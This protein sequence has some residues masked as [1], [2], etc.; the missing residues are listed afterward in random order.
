[1]P[2][3][4]DTLAGIEPGS[5]LDAIRNQRLQAR[6]HAQVSYESL[7]KPKSEA[8]ASRLERIAI[9]CFVAGLHGRPEIEAFYGTALAEAGAPAAWKTAIAAAVIAAKGQGP[10]G[11]YPKG[12][13]SAEDKPG[14]LFKLGTSERGALGPRLAAA[15]E[16]TH[17]LVFHPRDAAPPCLQALI[18]AGW[19]AT[20]IVVI[21]QLVAF[22]SYQIRVVAGLSVLK[23]RPA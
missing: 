16:H 17:M 3:V 6:Q 4:I 18:D 20:G 10:Y 9:A 23:A 11:H 5:P 21:S 15:F 19:S 1:M 13:L 2:D 14:P 7:F 22:L 12:P 8:D